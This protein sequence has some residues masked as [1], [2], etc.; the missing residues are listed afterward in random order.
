MLLLKQILL[1]GIVCIEELFIA[2]V[3]AVKQGLGLSL[4]FTRSTT[5]LVL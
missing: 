3:F 4:A 5:V 1:K 2:R